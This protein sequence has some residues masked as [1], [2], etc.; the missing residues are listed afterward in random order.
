M[1][2]LFMLLYLVLCPLSMILG[3]AI[4]VPL[5][6]GAWI[7]IA[8]CLLLELATVQIVKVY[9]PNLKPQVAALVRLSGVRWMLIL[10]LAAGFAIMIFCVAS[11]RTLPPAWGVWLITPIV[12]LTALNLMGVEILP[13]ALAVE[14]EAGK[15]VMPDVSPVPAEDLETEIVKRFAWTYQGSNHSILLVLRKNCYKEAIVQARNLNTDQWSK[16]YVTRGMC[17]EV[18]ALAVELARL[19]KSYGT[20]EEVSFVLAFVQ[21]VIE[22]KADVGEY[23][24]YPIET[25]A[26]SGGDCEDS[27]ILGAAILL[28]MGYEVALLFLPG[29]CVLGVAGAT[30]MQG[31]SVTYNGLQY[32]YCEMTAEG[33]RFG[34]MPDDFTVDQIKVSPVPYPPT[35]VVSTPQLEQAA[36]SK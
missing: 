26:E 2:A 31:A 11:T 23:P 18:Y 24:R 1:L 14:P 27:A 32:F 20:Y 16:V 17:G 33:W 35:K 30:G 12:G 8:L 15:I 25:L 28:A 22:Y 19:Q 9:Q 34:Q 7:A 10:T 4:G 5:W 21:H 36:G 29:H 13:G 6:A 3:S